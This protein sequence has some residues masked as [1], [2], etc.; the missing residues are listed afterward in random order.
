M[1]TRRRVFSHQKSFASASELMTKVTQLIKDRRMCAIV[2]TLQ[3]GLLTIC[4][5]VQ[6]RPM[7]CWVGGSVGG[8]HTIHSS[9]VLSVSQSSS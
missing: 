1:L 7:T 5:Y 9:T 8:T 4:V 2:E 6:P 3:D